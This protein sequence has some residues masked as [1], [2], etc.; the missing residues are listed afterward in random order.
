MERPSAGASQGDAHDR[1]RQARGRRPRGAALPALDEQAGFALLEVLISA[2][3]VALIVIATFT[4]FD[5]SNRATASERAHA[6][7]DVLAQQDEDRLRSLQIGQLSN[8]SETRTVKYKETEYTV[9][10]TGEFVADTSGTTSCSAEAQEASYVRTTSKVT[11][12]SLG[13]RPAVVETGLITPPAGGALLVQVFGGDGKPV[14]GM[15]VKATGPAPGS[16]SVTGLTGEKGCVIFA[17]MPEGTYAVT[18]F[19][20]GY[21]DKNG[22]S[23][24]LPSERSVTLV[25]GTTEKKS[26][27]FDQPGGL[28]VSFEPSVGAEAVGDTFVAQNPSMPTP[29]FKSFGTAGTYAAN[30]TSGGKTLFPFG[31]P[32]PPAEKAIG[33]YTV[34]AGTCEAD[35][36]TRNGQPINPT[37]NV[38]PNETVAKKVPLPAINIKVMSG[39]S[40]VSAGA[41]VTKFEG[42][43]KDEG[44]E[45]GGKEHP[46]STVTAT[47][48]ELHKGMPFGKFSLCVVSKEKVGSPTAEYRKLKGTVFENKNA[49]GTPLT[50][51]Y[52]GSGEHRSTSAYT[53][54]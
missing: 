12:P 25:P 54:P 4:G 17:G 22:N 47:E 23:E 7:A 13:T 32:S 14:T 50:T 34:Y 42:A 1:A 3:I 52:L 28:T 11:W 15:T 33:Q 10:S 16:G 29:S 43:F 26:F 37:I 40:S 27:E 9:V 19:Q 49:A 5:A 45:C 38:L 31:E 36:P 35:E 18:T 2:V 51:I 30:V 44:A 53:C 8:L 21:V 6:Q 46:F 20:A 41:A 24:P 39:S 48:G